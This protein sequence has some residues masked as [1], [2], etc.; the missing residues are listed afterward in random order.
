MNRIEHM[1]RHEMP[2]PAGYMPNPE[3]HLGNPRDGY[4]FHWT[5]NQLADLPGC[6]VL[7]VGCWDGWLDFLLIGA[8]HFVHGVELMPN[9][10]LAAIAYAQ[11][12][13]HESYCIYQGFWDEIGIPRY[14]DVVTCFETLEHVDLGLVP[15]WIAKMEAVATKRVLISLPDQDH[16]DNAQHQWTPTLALCHDLFVG[17][18]NLKIEYKDYS[19][20]EIP[21]NLFIRWDK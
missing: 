15:A 18:R 9:L 21:A 20:T 8:G 13:G 14:Y 6:S 10:A 16:R 4:H 19:G 7:D 1:R 5:R 3:G 12:H 11:K 17:K 2:L